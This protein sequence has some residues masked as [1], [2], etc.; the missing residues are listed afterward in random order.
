[1]GMILCEQETTINFMRESGQAV[2][3]TSDTTMI[4]RLDKLVESEAAPHWKLKENHYSQ[5][6]ELVA[7][8]YITAKRLISFRGNFVSSHMTEEQKEA[9]RIRLQKYREERQKHA[10]EREDSGN[11]Q[12]PS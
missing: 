8:T 2:I 6:G 1:M 4:T 10:A 7:K 11:A 3:Y 5:D 9:A 12:Q